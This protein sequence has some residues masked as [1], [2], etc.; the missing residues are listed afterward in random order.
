MS[1]EEALIANTTELAK[2]NA[3]FEKFSTGKATAAAPTTAAAS[4]EK[5]GPGRP[6]K[7]KFDDVKALA[8]KVVEEK[9]QPA[10]VKLISS[11]G[12]KKLAELDESKYAAFMAACEVLLNEEEPAEAD[13][14]AGDEI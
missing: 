1:L 4:G 12:A 2:F 9:G 6:P 7:I 3:N 11:H 14:E 10:C 5:R 13:A 8:M